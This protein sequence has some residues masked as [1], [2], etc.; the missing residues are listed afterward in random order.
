LPHLPTEGISHPS[1][2]RASGVPNIMLPSNSERMA[3]PSPSARVEPT[4]G[5]KRSQPKPVTKTKTANGSGAMS[6]RVN[7][8]NK[9]DNQMFYGG[10][11]RTDQ[12]TVPSQKSTVKSLSNKVR[13]ESGRQVPQE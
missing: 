13:N 7:G 12:T 5:S 2:R 4:I 8:A 6:H 3:D 10:S 11:S 1:P 9:V